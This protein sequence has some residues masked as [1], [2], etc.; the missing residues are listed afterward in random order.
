MSESKKYKVHEYGNYPL[1][2]DLRPKH[3]CFRFM[4]P[5]DADWEGNMDKQS[6]DGDKKKDHKD[7]AKGKKSKKAA[8]NTAANTSQSMQKDTTNT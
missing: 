4:L 7:D 3:G 8:N 1:K 5:C 2:P 6:H